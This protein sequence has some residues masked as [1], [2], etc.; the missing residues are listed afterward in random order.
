[1]K[2]RVPCNNCEG[3]GYREISIQSGEVLAVVQRERN[4]NLLEIAYVLE[5][6]FGIRL[7]FAIELGGCAL[8]YLEAFDD[9]STGGVIEDGCDPMPILPNEETGL[10]ADAVG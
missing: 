1:M 4:H 3:K 2:G 7:D 10:D 8:A 6:R 9:M 5:K